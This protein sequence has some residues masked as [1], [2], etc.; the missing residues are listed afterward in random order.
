MN[1]LLKITILLIFF[2]NCNTVNEKK[3]Y[4]IEEDKLI[5][6]DFIIDYS[7]Y[8]KHI[9]D[10]NE[11]L[12]KYMFIT[13]FNDDTIFLMDIENKKFGEMKLIFAERFFENGDIIFY[14]HYPPK[15]ENRTYITLKEVVDGKTISNDTIYGDFIK[16]NISPP[17]IVE[18]ESNLYDQFDDDVLAESFSLHIYQPNLFNSPIIFRKWDENG[19]EITSFVES[20][21]PADE[22]PLFYIKE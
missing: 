20:I 17:I 15:L 9:Y 4:I 21:G 12:L 16:F 1:N 6:N 3:K 7:K 11:K 8:T 19:K 10:E 5:E 22:E 18:I 14:A 13:P 2:Q